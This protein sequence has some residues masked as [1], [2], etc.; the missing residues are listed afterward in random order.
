METGT[1]THIYIYICTYIYI[2]I[3]IYYYGEVYQDVNV[4]LEV[5]S[6]FHSLLAIQIHLKL[7]YLDFIFMLHYEQR[8][9]QVCF[10]SFS[11]DSDYHNAV[12]A[13]VYGQ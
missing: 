12:F 7:I 3:Y 10:N 4:L 11:M 8:I 6:L 1:H 13:Y 9:T 2:Y 5:V